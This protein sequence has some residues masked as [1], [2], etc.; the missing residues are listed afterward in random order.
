MLSMTAFA[1]VASTTPWGE[2][3]WE[4]RSVN[5]RYLE[6]NIRL[7][8]DLRGLELGARERISQQLQRGKIDATLRFQANAAPS[9]GFHLNLDLA[10]QLINIA[11]QIQQLTGEE[12][13]LSAVDLMRWPGVLESPPIDTDSLGQAILELLDTALQQLIAHR[14]REGQQITQLIEQRCVEVEK[15]VAQVREEL[16]VILKAQRERLLNRLEE[17]RQ[18]LDADRLEQEMVL[19]AQKA[20][21]AEELDRLNTHV[22]EVRKTMSKSGSIGRRL[23]FL[24][25]EMNREANTLG[26]KSIHENTTLVSVNLKVLIEQMREQIQNIE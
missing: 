16:P 23:D 10:Q 20:D 11:G 9:Q 6:Q 25:Q 15:E 21:V 13:R 24:M 7:P 8:E 22:R 26:S 1:R 2:L 12:R 4:V 3:C 19:V 18:K 5:H 14:Q 17:A